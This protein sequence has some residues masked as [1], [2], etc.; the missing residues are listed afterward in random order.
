MSEPNARR[1]AFSVEGIAVN[2]SSLP[3]AIAEIGAEA[4]S[5]HSFCAFTLNL[6]HCTKLQSDWRF[7]NA[8]RRARFVTADGFPIVMLARL[9]GVRMSRTT[10][11][12]MAEPICGEAARLGLPVVFYGP[13]LPTL[14]RAQARLRERIPGL[15]IA[16]AFAPGRNFDPESLEADRA[17]ERIRESNARICLVALGAPRQEIFAARCVDSIPALGVVCIGAALDFIAG[18]EKRAPPVW[19]NNG[20][21]WLWRLAGDPR[22]LASRY[23]RC[24]ALV[25]RLVADVIPQAISTRRGRSS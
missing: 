19:Q 11:A 23:W 9:A 1:H 24:A 8:Y 2:L 7:R 15:V 22:R 16:D 6:D 10:G 3:E 14:Q 13:N 12:D 5:A 18:T 25:P 17:I 20:L 4:R 21:E